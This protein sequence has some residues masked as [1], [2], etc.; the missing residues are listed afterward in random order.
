[1]TSP[2]YELARFG[3]HKAKD[4]YE[5]YDA[6]FQEQNLDEKPLIKGLSDIDGN[7]LNR[8]DLKLS[9]KQWKA[10]EKYVEKKAKK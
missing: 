8:G 10:N 4:I 2:T 6:A 9:A 1:M 5:G 7:R 3:Y